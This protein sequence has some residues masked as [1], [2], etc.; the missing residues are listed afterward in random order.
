VARQTLDRA[1]E[2]GLP[3]HILPEWYDVDDCEGI[4]LLMGELLDGRPFSPGLRSSPA[5]HSLALLRS[6]VL[7]SDLKER[8]NRLAIPA[9]SCA[10][11]LRS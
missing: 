5:R 3:V 10:E 8:L 9:R 1:A 6:M 2:I 11:A 7:N 4:R